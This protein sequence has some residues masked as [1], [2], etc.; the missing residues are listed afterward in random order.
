MA[1]RTNCSKNGT[2]YYRITRTV[3]HKADGTPIRKEFYG[4]GIKDAED[5]ANKYIDKIN[6]G[7]DINYDKQIFNEVLKKWLF[8]IKRVAV[9]PSTF[10]T[11]EGVYRNY[12]SIS[13]FSYKKI[14]DIK[15]IDVQTYYNDLFKNNKTTEKIK[16]INKLL[17]SFFEYAI[18]E[19][20]IIKNPCTR[21]SIPTPHEINDNKKLEVFTKDEIN[22]IISKLNG[23]KYEYVVLTA[24]YTRNA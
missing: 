19:N 12:L 13:P 23:S 17:H 20:Y 18:D 5:K 8:T 15:K 21:I 3:G 7:Y 4:K 11:Y 1:K 10:V 16:S 9:K 24:I 6:N 22:Y 2:S 14:C